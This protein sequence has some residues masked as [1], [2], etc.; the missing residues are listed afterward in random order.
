MAIRPEMV[1][2]ARSAAIQMGEASGA[3]PGCNEYG[4]TEDL[5]DPRILVLTEEWAQRKPCRRTGQRRASWLSPN[6]SHG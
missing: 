5:A 1:E 4:F 3:E 2:E 6:C